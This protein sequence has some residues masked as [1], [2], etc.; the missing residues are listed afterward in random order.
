M[1]CSCAG[2]ESGGYSDWHAF[3]TDV[4]VRPTG[5]RFT[6]E[7]PFVGEEGCRVVAAIH[8]NAAPGYDLPVVILGDPR[9]RPSVFGDRASSYDMVA[10]TVVRTDSREMQIYPVELT[11]PRGKA[12]QYSNFS[13]A[14]LSPG[15]AARTISNSS[16]DVLLAPDCAGTVAVQISDVLEDAEGED[17]RA[18]VRLTFDLIARNRAF[19]ER[20]FVYALDFVVRGS[21]DDRTEL[22]RVA[23]GSFITDGVLSIWSGSVVIPYAPAGE[24]GSWRRIS[25]KISLFEARSDGRPGA[26]LILDSRDSDPNMIV[27]MRALGSAQRQRRLLS[28][29]PL[30]AQWGDLD[31]ALRSRERQ[32]RDLDADR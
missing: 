26:A 18:G 24:F 15:D 14:A 7:H 16:P 28:T 25:P 21:D 6:F 22:E 8:P 32:L 13:L 3:F 1:L 17:R 2:G 20:R 12:L 11:L 10:Q 9:E 29:R 30:A 23:A 27:W 4:D 31:I 5:R 19:S